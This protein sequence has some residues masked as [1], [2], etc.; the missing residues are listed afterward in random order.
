LLKRKALVIGTIVLFLGLTLSPIS[1]IQLQKN[2]QQMEGIESELVAEPTQ[3][4]IDIEYTIF[5]IDGTPITDTVTVSEEELDGIMA[6]LSLLLEKVEQCT[7]FNEIVAILEKF[8]EDCTD[9]ALEQ[10]FCSFMGRY[11]P[12]L[13]VGRTFVMSH[14]WG[15]KL[16]PFKCHQLKIRKFFTTWHY[17]QHDFTLRAKTYIFRFLRPKIKIL[18]GPQFGWMTQFFGIYLYIARS[19]PH[20]SYTFFFGSTWNARGIDLF[21]C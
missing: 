4:T 5:N 18:K 6:T 21:L 16:R 7:D 19:F 3:K 2:E 14:G 17:G 1:A 15:Y 11:L 9:P 12:C 10:I 8:A 20:K 13:P